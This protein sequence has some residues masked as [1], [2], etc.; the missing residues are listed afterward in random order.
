MACRINKA[1]KWTARILMEWLAHNQKGLP[2]P[3]FVTLTYNDEKVPITEDGHQT[4]RKQKFRQWLANT[5]K[6]VTGPFRYYAVGEYGDDTH[7]PHYHLVCFP[8]QFAQVRALQWAWRKK[9]FTSAYPLNPQRAGYCA[10]YT[11][12]KLTKGDD[13]RL[14]PDQEPE[15]RISSKNPPLAKEFCDGL[16][17]QYRQRKWK[18]EV[19]DKRGDVIR[20]FRFNNRIYPIGDWALRYMRKELGIPQTERERML[21]P[22]YEAFKI[23]NNPD[24]DI[25]TW[26][27][28]KARIQDNALKAIQRSKKYRSN[29]SRI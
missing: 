6:Q 24:E 20:V 12:K 19:I 2:A 5:Q 29:V 8:T 4:L 9:G 26:D 13:P 18:R 14:K 17:K 10:N 21:N 3:M 16:I 28:E 23:H 11:T 1:R 25:A 15:F 27:E 7:R 22:N